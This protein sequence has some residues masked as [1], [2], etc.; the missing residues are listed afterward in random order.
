M[1]VFSVIYPTPAR[2]STRSAAVVPVLIY[3]FL[4]L[5]LAGGLIEMAWFD[6]GLTQALLIGTFTMGPVILVG[7][8]GVLAHS[9]EDALGNRDFA[10]PTA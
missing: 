1:A 4:Y 8:L 9:H 5:T 10:P 7:L 6:P 3:G 2:I